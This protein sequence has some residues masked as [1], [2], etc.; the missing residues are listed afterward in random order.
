MS[1]ASHHIAALR[2]GKTV[3][4]R[5]HGNSMTGRIESGQLVTVAPVSQTDTI[6][7]GDAVLC[8]VHG[9]H[10][11]HLVSAIRGEQYQ[12]SNVRGY[13]NGWTTAKQIHGKVVK[14]E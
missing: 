13:V 7:V 4:F 14:V 3:Q 11:L 1:W 12:I 9:R 6:K 10:V 8:T 5:P 2:A